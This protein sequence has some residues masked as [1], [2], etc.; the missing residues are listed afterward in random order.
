MLLSRPAART[1]GP[2]SRSNRLSPR[3][4]GRDGRSLRRRARPRRLGRRAAPC[5]RRRLLPRGSRC[6]AV[7]KSGPAHVRPRKRRFICTLFLACQAAPSFL[8]ASVRLAE[9]RCSRGALRSSVGCSGAEIGSVTSRHD[10]RLIGKNVYIHTRDARLECDT[11][12][13]M[14]SALRRSWRARACDTRWQRAPNG[15]LGA[16]RTF[17]PGP[18]LF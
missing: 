16:E 12:A 8:P 2:E 18:A 6:V 10:V 9:P 5:R 14:C 7:N 15:F 17:E 4:C 11:A 3:L 13:R 1:R